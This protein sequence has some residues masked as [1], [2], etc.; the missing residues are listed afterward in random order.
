MLCNMAT[1]WCIHKCA[2][3]DGTVQTLLHI[4]LMAIGWL[5]HWKDGHEARH[6]N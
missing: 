6:M 4:D 3:H 2:G 5:A 1:N